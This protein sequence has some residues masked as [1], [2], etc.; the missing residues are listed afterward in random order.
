MSLLSI[1]YIP[2]NALPF[3]K[4]QMTITFQPI[5]YSARL[6]QKKCNLA[7]V[8]VDEMASFYTRQT[9]VTQKSTVGDITPEIP[10]NNAMPSSAELFVKLFISDA[11]DGEGTSFFMNAAMSWD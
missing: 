8:E 2:N 7:D 4:A 9:Q 10:A 11:I 6:E 5:I 3:S 1:A